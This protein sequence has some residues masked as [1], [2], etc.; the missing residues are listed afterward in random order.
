MT[1]ID[2]TIITLLA[3][4]TILLIAGLIS[5]SNWWRRPLL[6]LSLLTSTAI[7]VKVILIALARLKV[8]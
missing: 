1:I 3:L 4:T 7:I 2:Y 8:I 6:Y 5:K